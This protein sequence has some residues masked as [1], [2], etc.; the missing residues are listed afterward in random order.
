MASFL[1]FLLDTGKGLEDKIRTLMDKLPTSED[2]D[3]LKAEVKKLEDQLA[4]L[5]KR[6]TL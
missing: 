4:E 5:K 1:S 2:P 6:R 3:T